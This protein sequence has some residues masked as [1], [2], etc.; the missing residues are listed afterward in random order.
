MEEAMSVVSSLSNSSFSLAGAIA[1]VVRP[2]VGS[3]R[4]VL[5]AI[6]N[7]R[8]VANLLHADP[9]MLRDL[10]LTPMDVSCAL[11][12]PVWRDPSA[13]L[14]IWSIERRTAA[15]AAVRDNLAGLAPASGSAETCEPL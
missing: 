2:V 15:R 5:V 3:L 14:L 1:L 10:G 4:N 12:E 8:E 9:A 7:R 11:A 13:R 6:K